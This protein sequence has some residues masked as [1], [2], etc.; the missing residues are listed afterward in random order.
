MLGF[1]AWDKDVAGNAKGPAVELLE[2]RYVL[3]GLAIKPLVQV[4]AVVNPLELGEGLFGVRKQVRPLAVERV[5]EQH[6]G[7]E[8]C[9]WNLSFAE[10]FRPLPDRGADV[11]E[12]HGAGRGV[13]LSGLTFVLQLLSSVI[14]GKPFDDLFEA[15]VHHHIQLV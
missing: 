7:R 4:T 5:G 12:A 6:F 3:Q 13:N 2:A 15:A 9:R 11:K 1:R 10:Q 8:P 14:G